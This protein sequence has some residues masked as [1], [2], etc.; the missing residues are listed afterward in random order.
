MCI[1]SMIPFFIGMILNKDSDLF[2]VAMFCVS[3]VLIGI[4]VFFFIIALVIWESYEKLLQ[5]GKY[6]KGEKK[7]RI[8]TSKISSVYWLLV[9]VIYFIYSFSTNEWGYS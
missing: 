1:M 5:E 8:V 7:K 4:G 6:T 9:T 2:M 3:L